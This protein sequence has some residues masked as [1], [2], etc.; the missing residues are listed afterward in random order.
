MA[1][2]QYTDQMSAKYYMYTFCQYST[3]SFS[4]MCLRPPIVAIVLRVFVLMSQLVLL[5]IKS[6]TA[7]EQ[8][9]QYRANMKH[10][11]L[12]VH[13]VQE[14]NFQ[15]LNI[16]PIDSSFPISGNI[17]CWFL[18]DLSTV[19]PLVTRQECWITLSHVR[20][21]AVM[22]SN[23]VICVIPVCKD[24]QLLVKVMYLSCICMKDFCLS[25][26]HQF[27]YCSPNWRRK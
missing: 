19:L 1:Y 7:R 23:S 4:T 27:L 17:V 9:K 2:N 26:Q 20:W 10:R 13:M 12:P 18:E 22:S 24:S 11:Y 8:S 3:L 6:D 21:T 16:I 15:K 14:V 5:E 25:G